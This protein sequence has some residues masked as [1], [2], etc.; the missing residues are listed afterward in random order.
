[1]HDYKKKKERPRDRTHFSQT[2]S[3]PLPFTYKLN[4]TPLCV[5]I[6]PLAHFFSSLIFALM[7]D[8]H[9]I[10]PGNPA[11]ARMSALN[12]PAP[13][14]S[15]TPLTDNPLAF[16]AEQLAQ[17]RRALHLDPRDLPDFSAGTLANTIPA[18]ST[19]VA[20]L[21]Q[22]VKGLV[23]ISHELTGVT[24]MLTTISQENEAIR[25]ELHDVS[26]QLAN[27]PPTQDQSPPQAVAD[28]QASIC[29]LSHRVSAPVPA[30]P[31]APAPTHTT[32][33]PFV[34][35]GPGPSRKG[36]ERARA[37]PTA[38]P[39]A[40]EDPKYLIPF[41]DTKLGKAFGDP[42]KYARLCPHSY[43]AGEYRRGAYDVSS[44]TPGHLHLYNNP[45]PT[46]AQAASGSGSGGKD[47]KKGS[48]QPSPHQ[49]A[50]AVAPPVKK[51][52]FSLPGAQLRFFAPRQSP[53]PHPYAPSIAATFPD[54]AAHILR[55]SNCLP[56]LGFSATVDLRGAIS[57]TVDLRGA[58]SLTVTDK[59]TPAASYPP[60][61]DSLTRALNQ[62]FPVGDNPWC[63]LVLA[64]TAIQLAIHGLPLRFLPQDEEE[65][66]PYIRQA[67]LNDKAT[68]VLS[69]RY[70]NPDRD[71][72]DAKQA[73]AVVVTVD[74]QQVSALTSGVFILS[75]KCKVE[76]VF[77]A[78][79]TSQC[80]NCWRYRHAHQWYPAT[81]PTCPICA[82]HHT[83]ASHR[84]QNP[85]CPRGG[86]NKPVPSCCP[87]W[88]PH[89]CNCGN[90]HT[91]TFKECP[92]RPSPTS[93][94]RPGSTVPPGQDPMD[95]AV[96][97]GP[98]P[99]TPP[100]RAGPTEVDLVTSRQPPPAGPPRPGTI[101]GFG[102]PLPLE[103]QSPSPTPSDRRV[104]PG[105]D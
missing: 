98:A 58:I 18:K 30:L 20:L 3:P 103:A 89:C 39:T 90:D 70:L 54:I 12:S 34:N 67:I 66:F 102:G 11:F 13:S 84:W 97:G 81:H 29:D 82:L 55:E 45:S 59:A 91:A 33:T 26:S 19:T 22:L 5:R 42:E 27:L 50:S 6:K 71:S 68:L 31:Q 104:Y 63:T 25:E 52:P 76:L 101:Q 14:R 7:A 36:K 9:Q 23:T 79:R 40:A 69:A 44:F 80:R 15:G 51:G 49:V 83:R 94:T 38:T 64:P 78:N 72:R 60:Y 35:Q 48:K 87:T 95:M 10:P 65:L 86:N 1:M 92:A 41:Y 93:P 85:T 37:P 74:P 61:F 62:S 17:A 28:L 96:Y 43:E 56:P 21:S 100:A 73:T 47:K 77:S 99:S 4:F 53:A 75:Q 8:P 16:M 88:P 2:S 46:Y 105:N 24:Q 32:H 57:A